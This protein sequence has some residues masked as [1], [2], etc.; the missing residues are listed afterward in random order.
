[1]SRFDEVLDAAQSAQTDQSKEATDTK[2]ES[3][4]SKMEFWESMQPQQKEREIRLSVS[5]PESLDD[6]IATKA[7]E[8]KMTKNALLNKVLEHMFQEVE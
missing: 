3:K 7:R 1:M 5:I 4:S 8:L 6:K 2:E